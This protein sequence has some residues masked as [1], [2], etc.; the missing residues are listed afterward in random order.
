MTVRDKL[1]ALVAA[2]SASA[3]VQG[4]PLQADETSGV[5]SLSGQT[6]EAN[7]APLLR[8]DISEKQGMALKS[9]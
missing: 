3:A 7:P 8:I 1:L 9:N 5:P 2:L 4:A 6:A